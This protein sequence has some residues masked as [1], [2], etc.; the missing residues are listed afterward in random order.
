MLFFSS[1][2]VLLACKQEVVWVATMV[3]TGVLYAM[4]GEFF[5]I[6]ADLHI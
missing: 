3:F 4:M 6:G 1:V 5:L 2:L